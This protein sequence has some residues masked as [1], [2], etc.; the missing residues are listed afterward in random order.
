M[1]TLKEEFI[2]AQIRPAVSVDLTD[3]GKGVVVIDGGR[4]DL[5]NFAIAGKNG[6]STL[7]DVDN[8]YHSEMT[9]PMWDR[10]VNSIELFGMQQYNTKWTIGAQI[11]AATT[12][13]ELDLIEI[14]IN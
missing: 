3:L 9:V 7:K 2:Q 6:F 13:E 5:T 4:N 14:E 10:I 12:E 11:N 1:E 8:N